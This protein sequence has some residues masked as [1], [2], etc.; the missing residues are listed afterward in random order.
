MKGCAWDKVSLYLSSVVYDCGL[1]NLTNPNNGTVCF[2]GT[3]FGDKAVYSCDEGLAL[4]EGTAIR[5][6]DTNGWTGKN[7]TCG[8]QIRAH[9]DHRRLLNACSKM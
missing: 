7:P 1:E 3:R 9:C 8:R 4:K 5:T 6:C 2:T